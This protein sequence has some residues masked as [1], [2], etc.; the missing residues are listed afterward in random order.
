MLYL[1]SPAKTLDVET[2]IDPD[3]DARA[4]RP[5]FVPRAAELI[6]ALRRH[7]PAQLGALMSVSPALA[8]LN[9]RRNADWRP[10]FTV[11]NSRPAVL[12]FDGEVYA[13]LDARTLSPDQ[14]DWAQQHLAILSG[15]YGLL[16]PLDRMQPYR[17]EM[18][19]RLRTSAAKDLYG[20]WGDAI[21]R[22]LN[23]RL[24]GATERVVVNLASQ[25]YARAVDRD[26]LKAR[27]IDVVFEDAADDGYKV[28]GFFAKRARGAMARFAIENRI[29]RPEDLDGFEVGG[30]RLAPEASTPAC[31]VFRRRLPQSAA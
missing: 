7:T 1:L 28:I 23:R 24:Q 20:F 31:R 6:D 26:A 16:R 2:P 14:L 3:I 29:D 22:A 19:T 4:T 11:H 18:G 30:Y 27:V 15:L 12:T 9:A 21:A 17:L 25:E 5:A 8:A 13:G 10:R